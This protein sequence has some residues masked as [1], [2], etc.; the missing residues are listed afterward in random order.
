MTTP[1]KL[2]SEQVVVAAPMS[3]A[4]SAQRLWKLTRLPGPLHWVA[5]IPVIVLI[6]IA[7]VAVAAWY[8]VTLFLFGVLLIPWRLL[9]RH[10]RLLRRRRLQHREQLAVLAELQHRIEEQ[11]AAASSLFRT[12]IEHPQPGAEPGA[13]P[14]GQSSPIGTV[15][16]SNMA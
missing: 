16:P 12:V 14:A 2:Q 11:S 4:G 9:R 1:A 3:F 8:V 10:Q 5:A 13:N 6:A 15:T 7:W